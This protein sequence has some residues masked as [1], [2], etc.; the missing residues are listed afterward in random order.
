MKILCTTFPPF[1]QVAVNQLQQPVNVLMGVLSYL[2]S[3]LLQ[4]DFPKSV[5][6]SS[7]TTIAFGSSSVPPAT[8]N[9]KPEP[10]FL[11][12]TIKQTSSLFY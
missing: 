10:S 5:S 12:K 11:V 3:E 7:L 6:T 1:V 8:L 9:P 4:H 2:N